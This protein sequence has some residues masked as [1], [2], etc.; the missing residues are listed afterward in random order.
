MMLRLLGPV[1]E[2]N[3]VRLPDGIKNDYATYRIAMDKA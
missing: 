3:V 2:I 1:S